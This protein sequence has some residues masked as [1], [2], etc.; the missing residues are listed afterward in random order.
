MS[1]KAWVV[2]GVLLAVL[3]WSFSPVTVSLGAGG[4]APFSFNGWMRLA[5]ILCVLALIF[6]L[7]RKLVFSTELWSVLGAYVQVREFRW[8]L[9]LTALSAL[10]FFL[11]AWATAYISVAVA[12]I[13]YGVWPVL[14]ILW[15]AWLFRGEGRYR[16]LTWGVLGV[17]LVSFLGMSL[18]VI[19]EGGVAWSVGSGSAS[20]LAGIDWAVVWSWASFLGVFII[21]A[22]AVCSALAA[23][24]LRWAAGFSWA[25]RRR[26][27]VVAL[28]AGSPFPSSGVALDFFAILAVLLISRGFAV[29]LCLPLAALLEYDRGFVSWNL[30]GWAAL[31]GVFSCCGSLTYRWANLVTNDLAVNALCYLIP[32]VSVL[33]LWCFGQGLAPRWDLL[34]LGLVLVTVGNF[35]V[36]LSGAASWRWRASVVLVPVLGTVAYLGLE[37]W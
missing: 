17:V 36:N 30:I 5:T 32:A 13:L 34:V 11:F 31:G 28:V 1:V 26:P 20:G 2:A 12:S 35:A 4:A 22:G 14:I 7:Y 6:A 10:E 16:R 29:A 18:A 33:M 21:L 9:L 37:G 24:S 27:P 8:P 15:M 3:A 25:L 23:F 19:S